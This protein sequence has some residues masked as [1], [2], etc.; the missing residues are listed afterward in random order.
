MKTPALLFL[1]FGC[2]LLM[3]CTTSPE[4]NQ[5]FETFA[6][7][8]L[9]KL[10]RMNPELATSL[11]D[12][13]FDDRMNDYSQSGVRAEIEF[14]RKSLDQL[15]L[16]DASQLTRVNQIDY[17]ILQSHIQS[18]LFELE[19]LKEYEWNLQL[20]NVGSAIYG[21][22]ARGFAPLRE[23]LKNVKARLKGIPAVLEAAKINVKNPPRIHTETAILQ[24][25]GNIS[26]VGE[27]LKVYLDQAPELIPEFA[28][29]QSQVI[30]ALEEYG[31]WLEKQLLPHSTGNFRIGANKFRDKLRYT[32]ESELSLEEIL[33]RAEEDLHKTH[34][35]MF[36]TALP[37]YQRYFP[38]AVG[39]ETDDSKKVVKAVLDKLAESRPTNDTIVQL[40]RQNLQEIT[41][42]VRKQGIVTIPTEPVKVIVMPEFQRGVAV[43]YCDSPGPIE[44]HGETLFTISPTPTDWQLQRI[45]SFFREYNN[46]ML[47]NLTI[48]EAM[49]GHYLQ[50]CHS[51]KFKA[52]TL[53]RAVFTSGPFVEGWA[54]YA[55]QV[56]VE[57]GYGGAELKM[58]Q[59]KMR[60]RL[61]INAILDQKIHTAG[62]TEAEAMELMMTE[63]FQEE[64][65]AAGKWRRACLSSTQLSTY[66]VGN[67]E[68]NEIRQAYETKHGPIGDLKDFHDR[69]LSFGSPAPK[70]VRELMEL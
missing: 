54:T 29:V 38:D 8:Y 48:H 40:A 35:A 23:R 17:K 60:L 67:T 44:K 41:E 33:R 31:N 62:M 45:T 55:E 61:I 18:V 32:L 6:Q 64:G 34:D 22:T 1:L 20:Y 42:F 9:E 7:A 30:S 12:H 63:G 37:L 4:E 51:N 2:L 39:R 21:L 58:Q 69:L 56:M 53:T 43:A 26:L 15:Q 68:I 50:L 16:I 57:K 36:E 52:P 59:L 13:R 66:Y 14:Q 70:Y 24:N 28:S 11:G 25:K 27:E 47:Q 46:Y 10:L 19:N 49:P 3:S 5:D 65:E